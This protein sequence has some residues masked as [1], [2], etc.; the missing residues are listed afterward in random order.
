MPQPLAAPVIEDLHIDRV[1]RLWVAEA[2]LEGN[3]STKWHVYTDDALLGFVQL[4]AH[5][6]VKEIGADYMLGIETSEFG[7]ESV[8]RVTFKTEPN[9]Q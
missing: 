4:P 5:I 9:L 3:D 2:N 8:V 6:D 1:G 7:E